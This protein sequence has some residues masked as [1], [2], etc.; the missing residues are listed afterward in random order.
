MT[1][2]SAEN[3]IRSIMAKTQGVTLNED[4][5][6][7]AHMQPALKTP[8]E[9][10]LTAA[11]NILKNH[12]VPSAEVRDNHICISAE[13]ANKASDVLER[14]LQHGLIQVRPELQS[15]EAIPMPEPHVPA[16]EFAKEENDLPEVSDKE[17][18]TPEGKV[19]DN[20]EVELEP[21]TL[22]NRTE[23][24]VKKID[25]N[26]VD[27]D[28]NRIAREILSNSETKEEVEDEQIDEKAH[29]H[30]TYLNIG[31]TSTNRK[32]SSI[33]IKKG[34][35]EM[36]APIRPKESKLAKEEAEQIDELSTDTLKKVANAARKKNRPEVLK[37]AIK[38]HQRNRAKPEYKFAGE[39]NTEENDIVVEQQLD[40]LSLAT[41]TQYQKMAKKPRNPLD[42]KI[43]RRRKGLKMASKKIGK[44]VSKAMFGEDSSPIN[45]ILRLR[46]LA[47]NT[48]LRLKAVV[49]SDC[50]KHC[51]KIYRNPEYNEHQVK[52]FINGKHHEP[53][54]SF[55]S[56][57]DDAHGTAKFEMKRL[58]KLNGALKE[59]TL[60]EIEAFLNEEGDQIDEISKELLN[61]Y[62]K[63]SVDHQIDLSHVKD[64]KTGD[65][66][67]RER[68]TADQKRKLK[69]RSDGE[70]L[71]Y[72]KRGVLGKA[73]VAATEEVAEEGEV[74]FL[75]EANIREVS[76]K[77]EHHGYKKFGDSDRIDHR[78]IL[79]TYH[80]PDLGHL[81]S[82]NH[83]E[84]GRVNSASALK[85]KNA[86]T[87][88]M[89]KN[90]GEDHSHVE[91]ALRE[92]WHKSYVGFN[93]EVSGN[94]PPHNVMTRVGSYRTK[95]GEHLT[96]HRFN[97]DPK[98]HV[99]MHNGEVKA[100]H[101]GTADEFHERL[102]SGKH[103]LTGFIHEEVE[104]VDEISGDLA[105]RYFSKASSQYASMRYG[106][107]NAKGD[108]MNPDI[109]ERGTQEYKDHMRTRRNRSKG[110][111]R[112][113][114][115]SDRE[116]AKEEV[117]LDETRMPSSV[118]KHKQK[119]G[120]M[121]D[122]DLATRY[123]KM[124]AEFGKSA[125]ELA[126]SEAWRHGYGKMSPHYW[127]RI[128]NHLD[129]EVQIDELST[130]TLTKYAV[131]AASNKREHLARATSSF[132]KSNAHTGEPE[133]K[134]KHRQDAM[135]HHNK[136]INRNNGI[137]KA[138]NKLSK[139]VHAAGV[140]EEDQLDERV[141][142][143][144]SRE[145]LKKKTFGIPSERKYP[146]PDKKHAAN[147][148]ARATQMEKKGKLS[149]G[150][151]AKIRAKANR[152][153]GEDA[154]K[155]KGRPRKVRHEDGEIVNDPKAN[156]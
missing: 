67:P 55:H 112:A 149:S 74:P 109:P 106:E 5:N 79:T 7:Q 114:K 100:F 31:K 110:M 95:S 14:A 155:K 151:A 24:Q 91:L 4:T 146:M 64:K 89:E 104:Q 128:K 60:E 98:H 45:M 77:L 71:S 135:K 65:F 115:I 3:L 86:K 23:N 105:R 15:L 107:P 90:W 130:S 28:I 51:A 56:D 62:A 70:M 38:A 78:E 126:R 8:E 34:H 124:S 118:I 147:A 59:S 101:Y 129:E 120:D 9:E 108:R 134:A 153:L 2:R 16:P 37:A 69:N 140:C 94:S 63:K 121:S 72:A 36:S 97:R 81:V 117:E 76:K 88:E 133:V 20:G 58:T 19:E 102:T 93:E 145:H 57:Y 85:C 73:K 99:L 29:G 148:K 141:L 144:N 142:T 137:K 103:G 33:E 30:R 123:K 66:N 11:A 96:M 6:A 48:K 49:H 41:M 92:L 156:S 83:T 119:L 80:H 127:N 111:D 13:D 122:E 139:D 53:A 43:D 136:V 50:G 46:N 75:I 61:R 143:T 26:S 150:E 1:Y 87:G 131:K 54:D 17:D 116:Y 42:K 52:F 40:E 84:H 152:I 27:R 68:Y 35:R 154:Q 82:V 125:E 12:G 113:L 44:V 138:M 132:A 18:Q 21:R 22:R 39:E 32:G 25:E 10:R 47:E